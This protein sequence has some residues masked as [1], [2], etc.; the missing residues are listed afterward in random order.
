MKDQCFSLVAPVEP[1]RVGQSLWRMADGRSY[2][3]GSGRSAKFSVAHADSHDG[4]RRALACSSRLARAIRQS[5]IHVQ[6][7]FPT[8]EVD[9]QQSSFDSARWL[10]FVDTSRRREKVQLTFLLRTIS[11]QSSKGCHIGACQRRG[12]NLDKAS[13]IR[14]N[15]LP[16]VTPVRGDMN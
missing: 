8:V 3:Q 15:S 6:N 16:F 2:M 9:P 4:R 7:K 12:E 10:D 5:P 13:L 1:S 11:Q 14:S